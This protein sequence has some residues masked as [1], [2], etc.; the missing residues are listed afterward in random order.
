[1]IHRWTLGTILVLAV[2]LLAA[3]AAAQDDEEL[4]LEICSACHN[5]SVEHIED[6]MPENVQRIPT[7]E[8][9]ASCHPDSSGRL[10][11]A[12][13]AHARHDVGC[14]D[15]HAV[16]H[17]AAAEALLSAEPFEL[18]GGCHSTQAAAANPPLSHREGGKP[19]ACVSCHSLHSSSRVGRLA[20]AGNG[21]A[22]LD[23]HTEKAGPF[24]YPHP[25][26]E[27]DGCIACHQPHGSTNPRMLTRRTQLQLC[28]ECHTAVP[29]FHDL[30]QARYRSCLNC[31]A[32][33]HGSNRG[34]ALLDE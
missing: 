29:S 11:L 9:C 31:H 2:I 3:P 7:P 5:P 23:C 8:A 28:L 14:L 33:V 6:P 17:E 1:M 13:A 22:C 32:A 21:G 27:L 30:T 25:P 4:G 10:N 18:C 24:V 20:L 12:T 16:D 15:C 26:R 34:A 19:F